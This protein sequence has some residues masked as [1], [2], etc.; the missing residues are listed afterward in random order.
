MT[1]VRL[2]TWMVLV[3]SAIVLATIVRADTPQQD[4]LQCFEGIGADTEW[5]QCLT[6]M[7]APC[8]GEEVGSEGHLTCLSAER[9]NWR[10]AKLAAEKDVIDRLTGDGMAEL[11]GLM[12]AWP[13]FVEDKCNAVGEARANIS[14]D[15]ADLG[16]QISEYALLTNEMT[17]CLSGTSTEEYC[18]LR[19]E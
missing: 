13:E 10:V 11:S 17:A 3:V 5:N 7:F 1:L 6:I 18:Q 12:L 14:R 15:A 4:V 2:W 9:E 16:C 19:D 8:A